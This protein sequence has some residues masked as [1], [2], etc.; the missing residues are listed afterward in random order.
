MRGRRSGEK[1]E[2]I[3]ERTFGYIV[4]VPVLLLVAIIAGFALYWAFDSV[5]ATIPSWAAVI[6]F[7][8]FQINAKMK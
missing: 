2:E 3:T 8:L 6:I 1:E 4:L 7:L 5:F